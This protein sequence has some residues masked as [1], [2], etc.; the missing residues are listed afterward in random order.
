MIVNICCSCLERQN[1]PQIRQ[2]HQAEHTVSSQVSQIHKENNDS[3]KEQG[4]AGEKAIF[5]A[6]RCEMFIF[7]IARGGHHQHLL[8]HKINKA[9]NHCSQVGLSPWPVIN[10]QVGLPK[11]YAA[12]IPEHSLSL[13]TH[14]TLSNTDFLK[15]YKLMK[16]EDLKNVIYKHIFTYFRTCPIHPPKRKILTFSGFVFTTQGYSKVSKHVP[17]LITLFF[18]HLKL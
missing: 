16:M 3:D 2:L 15:R 12:D 10:F 14:H 4:M 17:L 5:Q 7:T 1:H 18:C 8:M 9:R 11:Q 6:L 13:D